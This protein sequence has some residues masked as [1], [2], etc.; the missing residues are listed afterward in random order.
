MT[1]RSAHSVSF[2]SGLQIDMPLLISVVAV[3]TLGVVNLYSATS[4]YMGAEQRSALA[5]IYAYLRSLPDATPA[6]NLP[7]LDQLRKPVDQRPPR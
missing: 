3:A 1:M 6:R 2:R 5:D 4:A 7:L